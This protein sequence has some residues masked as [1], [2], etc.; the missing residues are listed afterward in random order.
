MQHW[1]WQVHC[2]IASEGQQSWLVKFFGNYV[3][4]IPFFSFVFLP[5]FALKNKK[6]MHDFRRTTVVPWIWLFFQLGYVEHDNHYAKNIYLYS[7]CRQV[8]FVIILQA[9]SVNRKVIKFEKRGGGTV[10]WNKSCDLSL[11]T[12]IASL[13]SSSF[14][15]WFILV[16][17]VLWSRLDGCID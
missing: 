1:C 10:S 7:I 4:C 3:S 14:Y 5:K 15:V 11:I 17:S 12:N 9:W 6:S 13:Q 8:I 16:S 2:I